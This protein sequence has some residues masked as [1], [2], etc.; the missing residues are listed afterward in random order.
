MFVQDVEALQ[1]H[2]CFEKVGGTTG[3]NLDWLDRTERRPLPT[4]VRLFMLADVGTVVLIIGLVTIAHALGI[5]GSE[6]DLTTE[7]FV[8]G[9]LAA[10]AG[11]LVLLYVTVR[12][13][14]V[15]QEM[16]SGSRPRSPR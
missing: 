15:R 4:L 9:G 5:G 11:F 12:V 8:L 3:M 1:G 10:A 7:H 14:L 16:S 13:A 6:E 2:I